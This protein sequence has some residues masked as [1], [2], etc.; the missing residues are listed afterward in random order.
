MSKQHHGNPPQRPDFG[1]PFDRPPLCPICGH[2][3]TRLCNDRTFR[4][5][6]CVIDYRID[7]FKSRPRGPQ[8]EV[9]CIDYLEL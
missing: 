3:S 1:R 6:A 2:L 5:D 7:V 4:C 8:P 9:R